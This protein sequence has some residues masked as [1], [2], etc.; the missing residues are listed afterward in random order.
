MRAAKIQRYT[1]ITLIRTR[2]RG[3]LAFG[4]SATLSSLLFS[5]VFF[6]SALLLTPLATAAPSTK[7][8]YA[9]VRQTAEQLAAAYPQSTETFELGTSDSGESIIGLKIGHGT[10]ANLVVSTHHGNEYGS[11]EVALAFAESLAQAPITSQTVYIIPVLN[12]SGYNKRSRSEQA[13]GR[14]WDPN[15]NYPGPCATEGP[16]TL[17][18]TKLLADFLA[19]RNIVASATLHT[20]YPAVVYP[21]GLSTLDL[22]TVYDDL[23]KGLVS[24][25]TFLSGYATGNSSEVIYPADGTFEDYAFWK[26][27]IWSLLFELGDTHTPDLNAL[28]DIIKSNVPGMRRL[29][30]QAP[31][32][33]APLHAF[34]GRC[35]LHLQK[36]DRHD[37]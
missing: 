15:R 31:T 6:L 2:A 16:F 8:D 19:Q 18:S 9:G 5:S 22:S 32:T 26:E 34:T 25:A 35:A 29:F 12:I 14:N 10:T 20:Y 30:E 13:S 37:E 4:V 21:W 1:Q 36:L 28:N 27:G 24:A 33:R 17:K 3:V 7:R 23:F 11:T